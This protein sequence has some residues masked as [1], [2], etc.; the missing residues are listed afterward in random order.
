MAQ[1]PAALVCA[2]ARRAAGTGFDRRSPHIT[3]YSNNP[4]TAA[5]RRFIVAG[6]GRLGRNG[7]TF[8]VSLTDAV[9]HAR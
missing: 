8:P 2:V 5:T 1:Q 6:A 4:R 3:R 7:T 9:C